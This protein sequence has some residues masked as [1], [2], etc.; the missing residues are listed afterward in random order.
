VKA[1][2]YTLL[3]HEY[4]HALG[5]LSEDE[6]RHLVLRISRACFG[7][8]HIATGLAQNGPWALLK[9][10]PIN[11]LPTPKGAMEIV[12]DFERPNQDYIV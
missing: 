10:V 2:I 8:S 4:L 3:V 11:G 1:F 6:V 9:G 7:E 5:Y 12:K